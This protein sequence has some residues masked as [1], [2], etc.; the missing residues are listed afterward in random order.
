[1]KKYALSFLMCAC[2]HKHACVWSLPKQAY[3]REYGFSLDRP[4][5]VDDLRVRSAGRAKTL[6]RDADAEAAS[7]CVP[8]IS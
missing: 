6:P 5:L 7:E 3:Q 4:I 1:M 2:T 8:P